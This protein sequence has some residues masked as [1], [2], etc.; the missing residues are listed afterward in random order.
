MDPTYSNI[1]KIRVEKGLSQQSMANKMNMVV[2]AYG[3]IE[4]GQTK[5]TIERLKEI[6]GILRMDV[7]E[8]LE[9]HNEDGKLNGGYGKLRHL[10]GKPLKKEFPQM[11]K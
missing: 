2:S 6:G 4:R 9:Y 5:L 8:I 1:K 10:D 7:T 11:I 3:K